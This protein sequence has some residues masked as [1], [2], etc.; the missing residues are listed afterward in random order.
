MPREKK[1]TKEAIFAACNRVF[2]AG[3]AITNQSVRKEL[4]FGSFEDI[5]KGVKEFRESKKNDIPAK[6]YP[7]PDWARKCFEEHNQG[8]WNNLL[9]KHNSITDNE[10]IVEL[11]KEIESLRDKLDLAREDSIRLKQLE[12]IR[13]KEIERHER[14]VEQQRQDAAEIQK[15][16]N[17]I[18]LFKQVLEGMNNAKS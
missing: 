1:A 17:E 3:I 11:Q 6:D 12:E 5:T 14:D 7:I 9:C 2:D 15:L 10:V 13:E 16:K 18:Q 8:F 4:G